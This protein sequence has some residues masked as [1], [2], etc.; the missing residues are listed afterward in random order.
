MRGSHS[1]ISKVSLQCLIGKMDSILA[2][3]LRQLLMG[4]YKSRTIANPIN[5]SKKSNFLNKFIGFGYDN[6]SMLNKSIGTLGERSQF[7][8]WSVNTQQKNCERQ[9][10]RAWNKAVRT[11]L[12]RQPTANQHTSY[13]S[14]ST[15]PLLLHKGLNSFCA[16]LYSK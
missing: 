12:S 11:G 15:W 16:V 6:Y 3:E 9:D 10:K 8:R 13:S 1:P 7:T 14:T 5:Y 4:P 2:Q